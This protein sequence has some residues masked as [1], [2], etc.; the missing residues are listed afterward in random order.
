MGYGLSNGTIADDLE[1]TVDLETGVN[2][3][4]K[5]VSSITQERTFELD[6]QCQWQANRKAMTFRKGTIAVDP[7]ITFD[8]RGNMDST[9]R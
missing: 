2:G 1:I 5:L 8:P 4:V 6:E 3:H 7:G 9:N